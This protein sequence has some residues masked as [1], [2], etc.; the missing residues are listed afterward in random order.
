M[1]FV[2]TI[3]MSR[4]SVLQELKSFTLDHLLVLLSFLLFQASNSSPF[5]FFT[6]ATSVSLL[7]FQTEYLLTL[8]CPLVPSQPDLCHFVQL[9]VPLCNCVYVSVCSVCNCVASVHV[10][11]VTVYVVY[12]VCM[13]GM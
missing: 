4:V 6:L 9:C 10:V 8:L 3:Q 2:K 7:L 1:R 12:V 11:Y 13:Y 5:V